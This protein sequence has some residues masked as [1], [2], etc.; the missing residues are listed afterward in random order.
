METL[1]LLLK[2][3]P[4]KDIIFIEDEKGEVVFEL[5]ESNNCSLENCFFLLVSNKDFEKTLKDYIEKHGICRNENF[6]GLKVTNFKLDKSFE[7][8]IL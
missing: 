8:E 1:K 3:S 4:K 2:K 6:S 5:S 7:V